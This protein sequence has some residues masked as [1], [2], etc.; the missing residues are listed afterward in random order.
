MVLV[1]K[2]YTYP[3]F[4]TPFIRENLLFMI[5]LKFGHNQYEVKGG[6]KEILQGGE[7]LSLLLAKHYMGNQIKKNG[8]GRVCSA[9]G[10]WK[11]DREIW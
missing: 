5:I 11:V 1:S 4:L 8:G 10:E 9:C 7:S 3:N 6:P 2:F